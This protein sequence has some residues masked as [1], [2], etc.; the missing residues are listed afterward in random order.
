MTSKESLIKKRTWQQAM[1]FL[2]DTDHLTG[3]FFFVIRAG[4]WRTLTSHYMHSCMLE[5]L[6]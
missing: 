6:G 4:R 5:K 3:S 2:V 1:T